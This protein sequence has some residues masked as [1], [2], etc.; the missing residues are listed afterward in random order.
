MFK[1]HSNYNCNQF[2]LIPPTGYIAGWAA[3]EFEAHLMGMTMAEYYEYISKTYPT[4]RLVVYPTFIS[5][6][7]YH[8]DA[9][10]HMKK[11]NKLFKK[12]K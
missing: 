6:T 1:I 7:L 5:Y 11:L 4:S 12:V 9:E 10:S 2:F 8:A 3:H